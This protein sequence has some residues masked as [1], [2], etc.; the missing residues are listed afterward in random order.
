[1]RYRTQ[2]STGLSV[3]PVRMFLGT[4]LA[5]L[6]GCTGQVIE[7][8]SQP[9]CEIWCTEGATACEGDNVVTCAPVE[10]G[11]F[12]WSAPVACAP[13]KPFCSFGVCSEQCIDE[14]APNE[15]RCDGSTSFAVCGQ[16]DSDSCNDWSVPTQC[17]TG[18]VCSTGI[19]GEVCQSECTAGEVR[20]SGAG[21]V[22]CGD[23]NGDG[24]LEWGPV[25]PCPSGNSCTNGTCVGQCENEC[26]GTEMTCQGSLLKTCGNYDVDPCKEFSAGVA[27]NV[28]PPSICVNAKTLR[29]YLAGG[30]CSNAGCEYQ[31]NDMECANGCENAKCKPFAPGT[32]HR[33]AP[34]LTARTSVAAAAG[35]DGRIYAIGGHVP[36]VGTLSTV[37]AYTPNTNTW[38]RV[39]EL[40]TAREGAA[41]VRG[42]DGRIYAIGGYGGFYGVLKTVEAYTPSSNTWVPVASMATARVS[43]AAVSGPDGRIYVIGGEGVDGHP[44]DTVEAYNP[45]TN[46]WSLVAKALHWRHGLSAALGS[47]GG[48]YAFGGSNLSSLDP[49]PPLNIVEAYSV[50]TKTWSAAPS[51]PSKRYLTGA[52][53]GKDGRI[54]VIGGSDELGRKRDLVEAYSPS[55]RMWTRVANMPTARVGL[56]VVELNG[57]IYAIGGSDDDTG[58]FEKDTVEV[59]TPL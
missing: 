45:S 22:A 2:M 27:C 7:S 49:Y 28:P 44:V 18:D 17:T 15:R 50:T 16:F 9:N 43:F 12:D 34:M 14:C 21:T 53:A 47:N 20:C 6:L 52:A 58:L 1:M 5:F 23:R 30:T 56:A 41:A 26:A 40:S 24:C 32:W 35:P 39:A 42:K 3:E 46:Q 19:C 55:T 4:A 36:F 33:A 48:I 37:E 57:H 25:V 38:E 11:C 13:D 29:T 54:Y 59:Y 8:F 31:S 10:G 51:M